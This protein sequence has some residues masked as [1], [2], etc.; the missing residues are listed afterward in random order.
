MK[1]KFAQKFK[2]INEFNGVDIKDFSVFIGVNGSGKTHLLKALQDGS[3]LADQIPKENIS[4]FNLQTF[5]IKNQASITTRNIDD[6]KLQAWNILSHKNYNNTFK[7]YDDQ[8]K[9]LIGDVEYPYST[10]VPENKK[11]QY[12][13]IKKDILNFINR[14]TQ[15][16]AKIKK[17][18]KTGIF[19]SNKYV[20][21]FAQDD[22]FFKFANYNPDDYELLE[23]LS[24]MFLD[25]QRNLA[26]DKLPVADKGKGLSGEEVNKRQELSPW[27]FVNNMLRE[28]GLSHSISHPIFQ[29]GD[30][31][32]SHVISFQA[33]LFIDGEEIDFDDLS[34]GEKILCALA[35]TV[36][37]DNK[38]K[39]PELLLLDEVDA[40]L[41]PSM[42]QNLLNVINNIFIKNNCK[43][44]LATHSPT[45]AALVPE[46]SLFEVQKGK[47][48]QKIRKISKKDAVNLLSEGFITLD[49]AMRIWEEVFN[50]NLTV[51]S[52]GKNYEHIAK[53]LGVLDYE[54]TKEITLY[55]HDSGSG[56]SDLCG[57]FEFF[58]NTKFDKKVL[59][60]WDCD[61]INK[62][63]GK[64]ETVN[65]FKFCFNK[66]ESNK[67]CHKGIENLYSE[68]VFT[69]D[70][71]K[72]V[73]ITQNEKTETKKEFPD[74]NKN[75]FLN[76]IKQ[77]T[78]KDIFAN[79]HPL[80]DKI[81]ELLNQSK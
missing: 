34:S 59:F 48:Q 50:T 15:N 21:G 37:Q 51:F 1:I 75:K 11:D 43:V 4:Y 12:S 46:E 32:R 72:I 53:A 62:V 22:D 71:L 30:F 33:K 42:I 44:I 5:S 36:Y 60:V 80:I 9:T 19:E 38:S 18:L 55:R 52:E 68:D 65:V 56:D 79:F 31:V 10:D 20:S 57:L 23:S 6:E 8:I 2:S 67:I 70:L 17:L 3:V 45:T 61:S 81:K 77:Q 49:K 14:L 47:E 58:K 13:K 54:L 27:N 39:F 24:E 25:Y 28:F 16:N 35:I 26:A 63:R 64:D 76:K 40:S 7:S 41:H 29:A 78:S 66:N 73:K 69:D 74:N